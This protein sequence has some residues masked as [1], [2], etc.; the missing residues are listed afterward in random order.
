MADEGLDLLEKLMAGETVTH[1]GQFFTAEAARITPTPV[2]RPRVPIWIGGE[3]PAALRRAARW[4]GWIMGAIDEQQ[5]VT[6]P[7]AWIAERVGIIRRHRT[8]DA[9]FDVAVD[10]I[11][12]N[13]RDAA[14]VAEYAAAGATWWC[15][16][17]YGTRA[18]D[19]DLF[20]R[21]AAGPPL[22]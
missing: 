9:T 5:N 19:E 8:S 18:P 14:R 22:I 20:A 1:H 6:H 4:D 13:P 7:P 21:I 11:T 3:S 17:I 10:G 15:E 12:Q 16:A 2:Q